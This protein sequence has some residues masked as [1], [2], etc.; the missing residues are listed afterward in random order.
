MRRIVTVLF[1][2]FFMI[3]CNQDE[4]KLIGSWVIE[5]IAIGDEPNSLGRLGFNMITFN[6]EG[7]C[8]LPL[9]DLTDSEKGKWI[10]ERNKQDKF[11]T[12]KAF[13]SIFARKYQVYFYPDPERRL[14]C[15]KLKSDIVVIYCTKFLSP[16][17]G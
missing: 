9:L 14:N 1:I 7:D 16:Y 17:E 13:K 8:D 6:K 11:L 15:M 5:K 2:S 4:Q 12:I 3:G 10:L